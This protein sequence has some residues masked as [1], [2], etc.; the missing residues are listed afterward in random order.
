LY[1]NKQFNKPLY[2]FFQSTKTKT[3][4]FPFKNQ[5]ENQTFYKKIVKG[6]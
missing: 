2:F 1:C 5:K 3:S 4:D 6:K